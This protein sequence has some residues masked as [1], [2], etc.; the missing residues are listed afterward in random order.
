LDD[1]I[2]NLW[3]MVRDRGAELAEALRLTPFSRTEFRL[4]VEPHDDPLEQARRTV[5]LAAMGRDSASATTSRTRSFR[6][7]TGPG[8]S[9]PHASEWA[10]FPAALPPIIERFRGVILENKEATAILVEHDAPDTL[11]Y[12]DP[13]YPSST[14][15]ETVE[16][17]R[18]EMSED[19]HARLLDLL[20]ASRGMVVLSSYDN[21]LYR[22]GLPD[23]ETVSRNTFADNAR[24][25]QEVLYLNPACAKALRRGQAS[26]FEVA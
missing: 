19:D 14:R 3:R 7:Y 18:H 23:W 1:R 2:V 17:Y 4:A 20:R 26:I 11:F 9:L 13:P 8:R 6:S 5:V 25:R 21:D 15:D 16:D 12:V 22:T 10:G 24:P